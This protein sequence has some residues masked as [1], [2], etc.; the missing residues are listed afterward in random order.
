MIT[1]INNILRAGLALIAF[2]MAL[3]CT[4]TWDDHY[5]SLGDNGTGR[6]EGSLWQA[7]KNNPELSN[8]AS[9]VEACGFDRSLN[10][11][12]VF[13]VFA[14]T[15]SQFTAE[16][17]QALISD[18][19]LQKRNGTLEDDNTVVKEF[20]QNHIAL[21]NYSVSDKS[22]DSIV[23]MN[24]KYSI[25]KPDNINGVALLTKNSLYD[26]GVLFTIGQRVDYLPNVFEYV[27]KDADLD[28]VCTFLYSGDSLISGRSY[29]Q[30]YYKEFMPDLSVAGSVV[31]GKTHYL[32][33]VFVQRNRLFSSLGNLHTE[34]STY[35]F[36]APTNEVWSQLVEEYEPYFNYPASL[37]KRD[38]VIYRN[39]RMAIL[40]GTTFSRTFNTDASLQDSAMSVN[41]VRQ[42]SLRQL[43]WGMPFKYYEY[44]YPMRQPY[45]ALAQTDVV[46]CSNGEVRKATQWNIDKKM[47]FNR[48]IVVEAE[49]RSNLKSVNREE[50]NQIT[51]DS[52]DLATVHYR[53]LG[54]DS[55]FYNRVWNN[56]Y[57]EIA[58]TTSSTQPAATFY[59]PNVLS[60]IPYDIYLITAPALAADS[61]ATA[62]ERLPTKMRCTISI[63]GRSDQN[64][65][66]TH[67]THA[68][69]MDYLLLAENFTFDY[70]TYGI[71]QTDLQATITIRAN[72]TS[73]EIRRG[74]YS[75]TMRLDC[76]VL[77]PHGTLLPVDELPSDASIPSSLW[78]TPGVLMYPHGMYDDRPI[79]WWYMQR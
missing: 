17:A 24:G 41:C 67:I 72:V 42:Y 22:S 59:L 49:N 26:N 65:G 54:T 51:K 33:S 4:D 62:E 70:C 60:N 5:N 23:M 32:D 27:R 61:N 34:D 2:S 79:N 38:S 40:E 58:P 46:K 35:I 36:L 57:A 20:L 8:F 9:V 45:G 53:Y 13:T 47:T 50:V 63:P 43:A 52:V 10:G 29:P 66:T 18:Y 19:Q 44:I 12:Q 37:D 39:T 68:N 30:F 31:E 28:S 74:T 3:A 15:N 71:T 64:L 14:P 6:Q 11:K 1:K 56:G 55:K 69:Q 25:L 75:R 16:L 7:I 77:V 73:V 78:G 76:I 21:Y 48:Y